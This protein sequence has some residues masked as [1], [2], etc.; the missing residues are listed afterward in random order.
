VAEKPVHA[1]F[2][3]S[4]VKVFR[5]TILLPEAQFDSLFLSSLF[6]LLCRKKIATAPSLWHCL[7]VPRSDG[8]AAA[9]GSQGQSSL[10]RPVFLFLGKQ[11]AARLAREGDT[12]RFRVRSYLSDFSAFRAAGEGG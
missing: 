5:V 6:C 8:R 9:Y 7:G 2:F 3:L 4:K 1:A 10:T 12:F 11:T